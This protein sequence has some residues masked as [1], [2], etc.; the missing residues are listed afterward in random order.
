[1]RKGAADEQINPGVGDVHRVA[2]LMMQKEGFAHVVQQHEHDDQP[3]QGING[4][5]AG[6]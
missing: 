6:R 2:D 5:Q 1:M 4:L 3:T